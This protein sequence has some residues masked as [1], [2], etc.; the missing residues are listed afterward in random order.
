MVVEFKLPLGWVY[1][2]NCSKINVWIEQCNIFD[3][4]IIFKIWYVGG[5]GMDKK[6]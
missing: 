3:F 4:I 1:L 2:L 6:I 5:N